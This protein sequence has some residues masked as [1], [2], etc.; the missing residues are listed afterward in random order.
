M[1]VKAMNDIVG[2]NRLILTLLVF[3]IYPWMTLYKGPSTGIVKRAEVI[4]IA[5]NKVYKLNAKY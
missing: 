5:I 2:P 1:V 3:G 4:R